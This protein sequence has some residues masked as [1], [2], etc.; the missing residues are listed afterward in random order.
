MPERKEFLVQA[1]PLSEPILSEADILKSIDEEEQAAKAKAKA[2]KMKKAVQA[3]KLQ[4]VKAA[5]PVE[6]K[7]PTPAPVE[8]K[9][10]SV[11][12]KP[13]PVEKKPEPVAA[14]A[15]PASDA[16]AEEAQQWIDAWRASMASSAATPT[17]EAPA[18]EATESKTLESEAQEWIDKWVES[19]AQ[20]ADAKM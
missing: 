15:S 16:R 4:P 7:A 12:K 3:E 17:A 1:A 10:E 2:G 6:K 13:E 18:A 9:P 20:E 5:A 19:R 8:K 11:E 14:T